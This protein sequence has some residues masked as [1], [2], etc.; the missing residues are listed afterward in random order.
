V[1]FVEG[2]GLSGA[3]LDE[4]GG[5]NGEP[6]GFEVRDDLSREGSFEGVGLDEGGC[7]NGRGLGA[8]GLG[9]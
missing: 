3:E 9:G 4:S 8:R 2:L 5:T 6:R 1:H 7:E